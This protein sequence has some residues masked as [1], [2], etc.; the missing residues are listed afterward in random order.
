MVESFPCLRQGPLAGLWTAGLPLWSGHKTFWSLTPCDMTGVTKPGV[1]QR[2]L[3]PRPLQWSP[4]YSQQW[5]QA[6]LSD[7]TV[8]QPLTSLHNAY[9]RSSQL[10]QTAP[11]FKVPSSKGKPMPVPRVWDGHFWSAVAGSCSWPTLLLQVP[12]NSQNLSLPQASTD[13][14]TSMKSV[15]VALT[16]IYNSWYILDQSWADLV[17]LPSHLLYDL[18]WVTTS[19]NLSLTFI[20]HQNSCK[21]SNI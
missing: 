15:L 16:H 11:R 4:F 5:K 19:V 2:S 14:P 8:F 7:S 6:S 3:D 12:Q 13:L 17:Q 1:L 20:E 9:L 10:L 21:E 18:R